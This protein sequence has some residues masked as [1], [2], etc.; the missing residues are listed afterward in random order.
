MNIKMALILLLIS[1]VSALADIC[2]TD[3]NVKDYF[4]SIPHWQLQIAD[5]NSGNLESV[6][7]RE[8]AIAM[9][10]VRNGFIEMQTKT[11]VS[12]IAIALL[13]D[14]NKRP[15]MIATSDGTSVQTVAAFACINNKWLI[16]TKT[17]FPTITPTDIAKLYREK[18][19]K[20]SGKFAT[21]DE[22]SMVAHSLIRYQLPKIGRKITVY[23]SHPDLSEPQQKQ[24]FSFPPNL[25]EIYCH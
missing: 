7:A 9:L 8:R 16:V 6:Q 17:L 2:A 1:P 18:D 12:N 24:L 15:V 4:L 20:I 14:S 19:I 3:K 21:A 11:I 10:D 25:G 5:D 23:P 13:R 22:L